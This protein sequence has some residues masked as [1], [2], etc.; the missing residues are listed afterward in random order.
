MFLFVMLLAKSVGSISYLTTLKSFSQYTGPEQR[1][2]GL[3]TWSTGRATRR[4]GV[5]LAKVVTVG[6]I[7][8]VLVGYRVCGVRPS[9][10]PGYIGFV[11]HG[12]S[13]IPEYVG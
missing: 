12:L 4:S 5:I 6:Y 11:G 7:S 2:R 13:E 9:E 3:P 8:D 1:N 10:M